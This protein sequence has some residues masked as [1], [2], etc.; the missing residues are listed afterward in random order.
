MGVILGLE[1]LDYKL[2]R[3]IVSLAESDPYT[4]TYLV[5]DLVYQIDKTSAWFHVEGDEIA[6]YVLLWRGDRADAI[7]LWGD[8]LPLMGLIKLERSTVMQVHNPGLLERL[9]SRIEG[10][11]VCAEVKVEQYLDMAVSERE[12]KPYRRWSTTTLDPH[13]PSHA[14]ALAELKAFQGVSMTLEEASRAIERLRYHGVFSGDKL[15]S[16]AGAYVRTPRIWVIGDVYTHPEHRGRGY[17]KAATSSITEFALA[18]GAEALLHVS[19]DN[20]P[21]IRVYESLG[22]RVIAEKPWITCKARTL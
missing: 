10:L 19:R 2:W 1:A 4:H 15:V 5:Y 20:K 17:A 13:D 3:G 8:A 9:L 16:I 14:R 6:G 12:F 11:R 22:Y 18:S 21:A 7:H